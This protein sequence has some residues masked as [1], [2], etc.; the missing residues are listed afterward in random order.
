MDVPNLLQASASD[1][2]FCPGCSHTR[3]L[4][5]LGHTLQR[6]SLG[7]EQVCLVSDIG[8]I[9][10][11]DRY[12][13]CHTFHGLHGR[14][15][16]YAEGIKRSRPDL[17]VVVLIGDGGCGIGTGH[18]VHA[19]R[20]G[21]DITVIVCNNFNFGMTGGQHSPTTP[22]CGITVTTPHGATEH[23]F[24]ICATVA[25]N[26]GSHVARCSAF[27]PECSQQ[28][29]AAIRTPGFSLVD[30]WELCVAHYVQPNKLNRTALSDLSERL[31]LP[32]GILRHEP[33]RVSNLLARPMRRRQ[34]L[35]FTRWHLRIVSQV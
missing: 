35:R 1:M 30:I 26:G 29:E 21:V 2:G 6:L 33:P 14:S 3:V 20:R 7:P 5:C 23:V 34:R 24:D 19:A 10:I 12:F 11:S 31:G 28:I 17:T 27:D 4:E 9:G 15:V 16:T 32:F 18:L 25:A 13:S 8:C 22:P